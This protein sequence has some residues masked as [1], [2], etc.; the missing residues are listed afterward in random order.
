[1]KM[2]TVICKKCKSPFLCNPTHK[3]RD[4]C[5]DI[6]EKLSWKTHGIDESRAYFD[7]KT[8]SWRKRDEVEAEAK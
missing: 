8:N 1:M 3:K 2:E 6:C 5:S 4:F 7:T